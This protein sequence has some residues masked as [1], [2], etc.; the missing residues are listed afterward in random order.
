MGKINNDPALAQDLSDFLYKGK[1][2]SYSIDNER[3]RTVPCLQEQPLIILHS[4]N[5]FTK[6]KP[7]NKN[8][9]K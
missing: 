5:C 3:Q 6:I 8:N 9:L 4:L 7:K 2:I 1:N